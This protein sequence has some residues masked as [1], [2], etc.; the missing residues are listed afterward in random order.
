MNVPRARAWAV[1]LAYSALATS[2]LAALA[3]PSPVL[4]GTLLGGMAYALTMSTPLAI[5]RRAFSIGQ[6]LVGA[7]IGAMVSLPALER[8]GS[9]WASI[10]AVTLGTLA[11]SLLAGQALGMRRDV[12]TTTG[13]FA[14][15]AG[16]ASGITALAHELGADDRVVTIVQYLRVLLVLLAMPLVTTLVFDPPTGRGTLGTA[17]PTHWATDAVFAVTSVTIGLL[18]AR[19]ARIPA[20]SLLGPLLVAVALSVSGILGTV[21]VP[22]LLQ[23]AGYALI[24]IQVG[25]RFTRASLRSIT[26]LLPLATLL[27]GVVIAACAAMGA[28]LSAVTGI[29]GLSAYLATTPGGL[30][31]VLATAADSGADV[32]YVLAVQVIRVFVM[33]LAAPLLARML[34][35]RPGGETLADPGEAAR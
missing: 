16:G 22:S 3:L 5:P 26:K 28:L 10:L 23:S 2:L 18:V 7:I 34:R 29:D 31:A 8:L 35:R 4:F 11:I 17:P 14:M 21:A 32:T 13:A 12:S 33:L 30:Y 6:G 20:G 9:D 15:V 1:V 19:Y 25:L 24:G 27:I